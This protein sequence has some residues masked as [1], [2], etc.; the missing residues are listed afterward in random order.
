MFLPM[1]LLAKCVGSKVH[2]VLQSLDHEMEGTLQTFDD[3]CNLVLSDV[4][5]FVDTADRGLVL[6]RKLGRC[7]VAGRHVQMLVPGGLPSTRS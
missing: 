7:I 4:A 5:E 6:V 1:E 3:H 2:V